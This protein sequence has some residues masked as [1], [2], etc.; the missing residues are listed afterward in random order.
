MSTAVPAE[1]PG[2]PSASPV[3]GVGELTDRPGRS[4][5][6]LAARRLVRNRA[7]VASL[8]ILVVIVLSC[9]AAPLYAHDIAHTNPFDSSLS[10]TT[11]VNGKLTPVIVPD[12][13]GL[14]S[15]PIG[16]TLQGHYF[17]GADTQGRD[18]AARLLYAGRIS[19]VAG[20]GAAILTAVLA[21]II[22]LIAGMAGGLIDAILSRLL[23]LLWAF[24]V[25]LL[26]VCLSTVLLLQGIKLGPITVSPNSI[27]LPITIIGVVYIPYLARPVRGE[28]LAAKERDFMQA[29]VAQGASW[30]RL[31]FGELLP[32]VLPLVIVFFPLLIATDILTES[33]LSYL[34]IG[35]Q[36]PQASLGTMVSDGQ[37]QLYTRP[38]VS[39]GPGLL[40][41][42]V[43][44]AL[45]VLG[46][47]V[48]DAVDPRGG[49]PTR[50]DLRRRR[51]R[52]GLSAGGSPLR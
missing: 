13:S 44:V 38:W 24:P 4:P 27:W 50:R 35:V 29:A 39:I 48:R 2:S 45:N 1:P 14:G 17:L 15:T 37:S 9:V 5:S 46:D 49:L 18:V 34:S 6:A 20:F 19:L 10:G 12:P 40:I 30:L 32:N 31:V 16:P 41:V 26:A 8:V 33:A 36:A 52:A 43:V 21:T 3:V 47:G 28:V 51:R 7:A 22:G 23:E 42:I 25:Y 11:I